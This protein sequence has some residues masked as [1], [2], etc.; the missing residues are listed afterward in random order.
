MKSTTRSLIAALL[1]LGA[2]LPSLTVVAQGKFTLTGTVLDSLNH[3]PLGFATVR[4]INAET[5]A[6]VNGAITSETGT[7]SLDLQAGR[8][9]AEIDFMGYR[10]YRSPVFSLDRDNSAQDIGKVMLAS[11]SKT[12]DEVVIQA[13]K[14]SMELTLDKR[15]FNVGQDLA[16]RGGTA[17]DILMNVPSVSVDPEG[18]VRLRGSDNVRILID[19]KPSGLVSFKGGSGLQQLQASMIERVEVI[20]NPSARYE[21][22]GM[23]GIINIVL[24]KDN[25][26][27]FNGSFEV[28]TGHPVNYGAA[29]NV[30]FRHRKVNF[31]VNYSI[32]Y[33]EQPGVSKQ[34]QEAYDQGLTHITEQSSKAYI[35]GFN[36][37]IRGGID[38]FFSEKS[39]L[40]GSYLWRRSDANRVTNIHYEDF[41]SPGNT[42]LGSTD[43][44]QDEDEV[45]P[46]SEYSLIYKRSFNRKGHEFTGEVKYLD[47][48]ES[49]NQLFTTKIYPANETPASETIETSVNDEYEKQFL[50]QLDYVQPFAKEGKFETGVRTSFRKMENDYIVSRKNDA[51]GYDPLPGLDNVFLYDEN[52]HAAYG[53][54]GNKTGKFSYQ[55][56][57]RAEWTD[58]KT[59]LVETNE[60]NPRKY[61]N[62]F[63]SAHV[64]VDLPSQNAIQAS[65]SRRVRRPFYNDLSP[66]MTFSDNRNFFSGNPDLNP[67]FSDVFE[68]GHIK[69]FEIGTLTSSVYYRDTDDKIQSIRTVDPVTGFARTMPRNL[70][71]EQSYGLEFVSGLTPLK[72]WKL[73]LNFNFFHSR[74]DGSNIDETYLRTT[75]SWF[76]RATNRFTLTKGFDV[77]VRANYE[78][79]QKTAQ[80]ERRELY[81]FDLSLSKDL[82]KGRGTLTLSVLDLLNSR[83]MR[84]VTEGEDFY[85]YN[86]SQF[87]RRQINLTF[88]YRIKQAKSAK[89]VLS[90]D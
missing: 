6:L 35:T 84:T 80:G 14:S 2:L 49:S 36:N 11:S 54:L 86:N 25:S 44:R 8:Y 24:K 23:A 12:L 17:T 45:E 57:L 28:I 5:N 29:A 10:S 82:L 78:A 89:R 32:A 83:R 43:R 41:L 9:V 79:P 62:L 60:V 20:T 75:Y 56:G 87:R 27:G 40:T 3:A 38:F 72:W 7:F 34:Y 81:Y 67:E 16:N 4:V 58:V 88:S 37:S 59:T 71:G 90:D 18:G 22:E 63:P 30:N 61:A 1:F 13:E 68:V 52:I 47:N 65:Y 70:K 85:T 76:A 73:D 19:G 64:T 69:Y 33:R 77:Q 50:V 31:F 48:W 26:Q 46:N 74:I 66:F 42:P 55:A 15:I 53:I 51:G 39:V 21:A